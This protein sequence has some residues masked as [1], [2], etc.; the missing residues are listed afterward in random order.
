M[1]K[2][3]KYAWGVLKYL[4]LGLIQGSSTNGR[5]FAVCSLL[6]K[7]EKSADIPETCKEQS[8]FIGEVAIC[9]PSPQTIWFIMGVCMKN[10]SASGAEI[11]N[12]IYRI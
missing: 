9:M 1:R 6:I 10:G 2:F 3:S 7:R 11:S 8:A 12:F 5:P 4:P